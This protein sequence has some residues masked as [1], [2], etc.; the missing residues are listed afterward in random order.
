M[1][2]QHLIRG[3]ATYPHC[4]GG[5]CVSGIKGQCQAKVC[6]LCCHAV[7][8]VPGP[9]PTHV[10]T[11][12]RQQH[13]GGLEVTMHHACTQKVFSQGSRSSAQLTTIVANSM[14]GPVTYMEEQL[15]TNADSQYAMQ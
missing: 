3:S 5:V 1:H 10:L 4:H 6:H 12:T 14:S 9:Q 2:M 7:S 13:V 15:S 11:A 8:Q